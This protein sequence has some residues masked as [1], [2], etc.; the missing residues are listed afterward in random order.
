VTRAKAVDGALEPFQ[1]MACEQMIVLQ[2]D[3]VE[4]A[5]SDD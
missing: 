1:V 5:R 4:E 2:H 3:H